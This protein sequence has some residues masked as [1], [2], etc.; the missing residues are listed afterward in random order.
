MLQCSTKR[1]QLM[2]FTPASADIFFGW[3]RYSMALA[4]MTAE[5]SEIIVRRTAR[6]AHGQMTAQEAAEMVLEKADA[7]AKSQEHAAK[8]VAG[9]AA[10]HEILGA[11]LK[12][13]GVQTRANVT[14]LR[15]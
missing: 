8:A 11:A 15:K 1:T 9:G 12:P 2:F 13:Y 6:M 10:P 3:A 7:F 5:A 4:E 14:E